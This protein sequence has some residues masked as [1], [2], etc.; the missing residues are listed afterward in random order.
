MTIDEI[1]ERVARLERKNRR[2]TLALVLMG[3]TAAL[4]AT[5][6]LALT[7]LVPQ[8]AR[9]RN[10]LLLDDHGKTR[11]MLGMDKD[12]PRLV[13]CDENGKERALLGAFKDGSPHLDL[14]DESGRNRA[15]LTV[16]KD[17]PVLNLA[18]GNGKPRVI[19]T[20]FKDSPALGLVDAN[21]RVL[22][23]LPQ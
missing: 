8:V 19:L 15:G 7:C 2:L 1:G 10:F 9:A 17:G 21:G 3:L 11:A 23:K 12:G 20:V 13:L 5:V 14:W 18:D 4:L 6:A 22:G 16:S